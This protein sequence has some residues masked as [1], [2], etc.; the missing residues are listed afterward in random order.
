MVKT[1]SPVTDSKELARIKAQEEAIKLRE[2]LQAEK[3]PIQKYVEASREISPHMVW[4]SLTPWK[5]PELP[6]VVSEVSALDPAHTNQDPPSLATGEKRVV[7]IRQEHARPSQAPTDIEKEW[8]ISFQDDG[9]L[10]QCWEVRYNYR[11]L[12]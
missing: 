3:S 4:G 5:D 9:E 2:A 6:Q 11:I 8:V 10:S 12:D 7:L 1:T